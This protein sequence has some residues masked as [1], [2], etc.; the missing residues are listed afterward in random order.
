VDLYIVRHGPAGDPLSWSGPDDS[1]PLTKKGIAV[2]TAVAGRLGEL[3][4]RPDAIVT[5]PYVRAFQTAEIIARTLGRTDRLE[6]DG[7]LSAGFELPDLMSLL[8]DYAP[9]PSLMIVGHEPDLGDVLH[10]LTGLARPR[11]RKAAVACVQLADPRTAR[12]ELQWFAPP[13]VLVGGS[14]VEPVTVTGESLGEACRRVRATL[15]REVDG[16]LQRGLSEQRWMERDFGQAAGMRAEDALAQL[17]RLQASIDAGSPNHGWR[18]L[19]PALRRYYDHYAGLAKRYAKDPNELHT[20]LQAIAGMR[21][22]VEQLEA[23]LGGHR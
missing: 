16:W 14:L 12:G 8:A 20:Q 17:D 22:E 1:R 6:T 15:A 3:G 9:V 7:R 13:A 23:L 2:V 5:S 10:E 21:A 19:L 4:V 18:V 11:V